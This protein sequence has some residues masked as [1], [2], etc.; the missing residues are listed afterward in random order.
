MTLVNRKTLA[1]TAIAAAVIA[2][3]SIS[4]NPAQAKKVKVRT[5]SC[6]A[7]AMVVDSDPNG[8]NVRIAPSLKGR[9]AGSLPYQ[10]QVLIVEQRGSWARINHADIADGPSVPV[11]GWVAMNRLGVIPADGEPFSGS[12]Q[13][14]D[15]LGNF[16]QGEDEMRLN[17]CRGNWVELEPFRYNS[18]TIW[19]NR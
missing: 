18:P 8:L 11:N 3:A 16:S 10:S 15:E 12:P 19:L 4:A 2:T 5:A 9:I 1:R 17:G 13:A 14:G 6:N 7:V